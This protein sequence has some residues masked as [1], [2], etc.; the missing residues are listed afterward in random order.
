[1][2]IDYVYT[3]SYTNPDLT[4]STLP[5]KAS[6]SFLTFQS[7]EWKVYSSYVARAVAWVGS[8]YPM[9]VAKSQLLSACLTKPPFFQ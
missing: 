9:A 8:A 5:M 4:G 1:M 2:F 7:P 6:K 3:L